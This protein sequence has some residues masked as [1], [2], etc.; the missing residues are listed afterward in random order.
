MG[1]DP[2]TVGGGVVG[3]GRLSGAHGQGAVDVPA[4]G[5]ADLGTSGGLEDVPEHVCG[6]AQSSFRI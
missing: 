1:R 3:G 2:Q 5:L 6:A 4:R